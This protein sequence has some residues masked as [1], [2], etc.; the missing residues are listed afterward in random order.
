VRRSEHLPFGVDYSNRIARLG[1]AAIDDVASENP[2]MAGG[3]A[4]GAFPIDANN[5]QGGEGLPAGRTLRTL[6]HH[7]LQ[8]RDPIFGRGVGGE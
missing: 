6:S 1:L 2:G 5:F 4:V 8:A 3:E 7:S